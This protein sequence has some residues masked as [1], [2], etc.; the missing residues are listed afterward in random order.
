M[1]IILLGF[2]LDKYIN[3]ETPVNKYIY[4]YIYIYIGWKC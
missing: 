2:Y 4:I 1:D 3:N